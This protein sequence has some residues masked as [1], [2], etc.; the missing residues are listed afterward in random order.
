M[1]SPLLRRS[2]K[3]T[4]LTHELLSLKVP[5]R[6]LDLRSRTV[7]REKKYFCLTGSF[8]GY[9]NSYAQRK[10]MYPTQTGVLKL[11]FFGDRWDVHVSS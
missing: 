1:T 11:K 4:E 2:R 9:E 6:T 3:V 5:H 7:Q 10:N 8:L